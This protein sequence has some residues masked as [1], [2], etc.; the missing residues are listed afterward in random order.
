MHVFF[1]RGGVSCGRVNIS[2]DRENLTV[3]QLFDITLLDD[4]DVMTFPI[5]FSWR[6]PGFKITVLCN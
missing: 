3:N 1:T 4:S 6:G 5:V 2:S